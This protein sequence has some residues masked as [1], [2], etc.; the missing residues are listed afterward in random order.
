MIYLRISQYFIYVDANDLFKYET[1]TTTRAPKYKIY[2]SHAKRSC[3]AHF[4][5]Q[6]TI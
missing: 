2:K 6:R 5:T 1:F 4:F 3:R